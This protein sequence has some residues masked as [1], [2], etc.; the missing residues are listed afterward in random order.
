MC[1]LPFSFFKDCEGC[2]SGVHRIEFILVYGIMNTWWNKYGDQGNRITRWITLLICTNASFYIKKIHIFFVHCVHA[3]T[4]QFSSYNISNH[5]FLC[6]R[7]QQHLQA[8][9]DSLHTLFDDSFLSPFYLSQ[10]HSTYFSPY[11]SK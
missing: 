10:A 6:S 9:L 1:F 7:F 11:T 3:P 5:S 2:F 4:R 8:S